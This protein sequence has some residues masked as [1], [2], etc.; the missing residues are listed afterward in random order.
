MADRSKMD[1]YEVSICMSLLGFG[2][3]R[4]IKF[5]NFHMCGVMM[6]FNAMLYMLVRYVSRVR[7][8]YK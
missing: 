6:L 3:G 2:M 4:L 5:A 1:M 7:N 8:Y